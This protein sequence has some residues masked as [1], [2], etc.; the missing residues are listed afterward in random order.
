M[1]KPQTLPVKSIEILLARIKNEQE[2]FYFYVSAMAWCR[3]NGYENCSKYFEVEAY[4]EQ[5]HYKKILNFL[6]DWNTKTFY[7]PPAEAIKSFVNLQDIF[8]QAYKMELKL[9]EQ[10][11]EDARQLFPISQTTYQFV[12][13]FISIQGASVIE[14]NNNLKKLYTYLETDPNLTE[15]DMVVFGQYSNLA[16]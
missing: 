10:Y 9:S 5:W 13:E 8:E 3:L 6:A 2:E 15:F 4:G 14:A 11:E 16:Y 12:Q 7:T 1:I